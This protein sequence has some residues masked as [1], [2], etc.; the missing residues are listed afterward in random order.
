MQNLQP[1]LNFLTHADPS[2]YGSLPQLNFSFQFQ[3]VSRQC[4]RIPIINDAITEG[5]EYFTL[6]LS[7]APGGFAEST[8]V[9][10]RGSMTRVD[11][12]EMCF[13]GEIRLRDGFDENQG[14]VEV[15]FSGVW[16]TV[17]DDG[18]QSNGLNN[19]VVVCRQLGLFASGIRHNYTCS[20]YL[21]ELILNFGKNLI[22]LLHVYMI[23]LHMMLLHMYVI[24]F[25]Y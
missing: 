13:D 4:V 17:C 2:D 10:E 15:C 6:R 16:G 7:V 12:R 9:P 24:I 18:W 3:F 14:R 20:R 1:D 21:R 8:F 25:R 19:A 5:E 22:S 23:L 11:I